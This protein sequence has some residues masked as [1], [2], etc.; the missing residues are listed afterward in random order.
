MPSFTLVSKQ[1]EWSISHKRNKF[2]IVSTSIILYTH[3]ICTNKYKREAT[4]LSSTFI[5]NLA[6]PWRRKNT[7]IAFIHKQISD[8]QSICVIGAGCFGRCTLY[9]Y[10]AFFSSEKNWFKCSDGFDISRSV[11]RFRYV[12]DIPSC[13]QYYILQQTSKLFVYF[14]YECVPVMYVQYTPMEKS[15][16]KSNWIPK[17]DVKKRKTAPPTNYHQLAPA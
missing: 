1:R 10:S 13:C 2:S 14:I 17:G 9:L 12:I 5:S 11:G 15:G 7:K 16:K 8:G 6:F 3:T 4:F